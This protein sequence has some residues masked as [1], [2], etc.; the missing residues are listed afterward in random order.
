MPIQWSQETYLKVLFTSFLGY[1]VTNNVEPGISFC[2]KYLA[3]WTNMPSLL[4]EQ[5]KLKLDQSRSNSVK[6]SA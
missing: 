4:H 6:L 2:D 3:L 1:P 5:L